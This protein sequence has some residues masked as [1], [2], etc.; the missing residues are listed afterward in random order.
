MLF[1]I[2]NDATGLSTH[3]GVLEFVAEEGRAYL[4]QWVWDRTSFMDCIG[5]VKPNGCASRDWHAHC[6]LR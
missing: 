3:C 1:Q 5:A 6:F 2:R 4:P